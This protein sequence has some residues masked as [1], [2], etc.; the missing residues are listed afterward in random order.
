YLL[1]GGY[2]VIIH[3]YSRNTSDLVVVISNEPENARRC[4]KELKEFGFSSPDLNEELFSA[5][6]KHVVRMGFP[7]VKIEI[8]NYLE[9]ADFDEAFSRRLRERVEDI[10]VDVIGLDDLIANKIGVG[11]LQ[12]LT[13]VKNSRSG[14]I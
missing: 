5:A 6:E 9:G 3:G 11:R 4:V 10:L 13:D 2:A 8:L 7:P 12:D 1:I 14:M